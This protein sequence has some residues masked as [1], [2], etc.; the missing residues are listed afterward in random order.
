M[1]IGDWFKRFKSNAATMEDYREGMQAFQEK[2][3][4]KFKGR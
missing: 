1:G 4:P 3:R 2:R